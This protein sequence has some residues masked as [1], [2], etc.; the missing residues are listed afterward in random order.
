VFSTSAASLP[1]VA[2]YSNMSA[3][4]ASA[5]QPGFAGMTVSWLHAWVLLLA[6]GLECV[7]IQLILAI[8]FDDALVAIF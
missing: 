4:T 2:A 6:G 8:R 1:L 3:G 7:A 5:V